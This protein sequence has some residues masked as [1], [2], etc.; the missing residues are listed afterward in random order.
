MQ[1][2]DQYNR[3][4]K[5]LRVSLTTNCNLSCYYC[6][7]YERLPQQ[8]NKH[9]WQELAKKVLTI[10]QTLQLRKIR[11]TGGEPTLYP[12]LIEL[13]SYLKEHTTT[14][15]Y[16]T[17][18]GVLLKKILQNIPVNTFEC[19][20]LSIDAI[21]PEIFYRITH[22]Y[23][24]ENVLEAFYFGIEH[25]HRF[26]INTVVL[27]NINVDQIVPLARW[28]KTYNVPIR[29]IEFMNMGV[30]YQKFKNYFFSNQRVLEILKSHFELT[31]SPREP[32]A[33]AQY[34]KDPE[35]WQVGF[36]SNH[37]HSFCSDCDRLRMDVNGK[38]YGCINQK[39][40]LYFPEN[41]GDEQF[42]KTLIRQKNNHFIGSPL[43]MI[44][45]GG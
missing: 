39:E 14:P 24:L 18:N 40:G 26:K 10:D 29:Y 4:F 41:V 16:L 30:H 2:K 5:T 25:G 13:V 11:L 23:A 33:T 1:Y 19:I 31:P 8:A 43:P 45:I 22:A 7:A 38:L 37:S 6:V 9:S 35:G 36:I 15:I 17:T 32:H 34:Y 3:E 21:D 20:N 28:A 12:H 42:W 44:F 27:N